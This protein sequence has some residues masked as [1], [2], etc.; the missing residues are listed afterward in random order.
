MDEDPLTNLEDWLRSEIGVGSSVN[1]FRGF[2]RQ[3]VAYIRVASRP[4]D[5]TFLPSFHLIFTP[6][7]EDKESVFNLNLVTFNGKV[8]DTC[9][10]DLVRKEQNFILEKML[11]S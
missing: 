1:I 4:R 9:Q 11:Q 10:V 6:K 5:L 2:S 3:N 7:E 8:I